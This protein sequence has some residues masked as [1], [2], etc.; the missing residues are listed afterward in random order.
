MLTRSH[1]DA[2]VKIRA[3]LTYE[4]NKLFIITCYGELFDFEF[5]FSR[6]LA[7]SFVFFGEIFKANYNEKF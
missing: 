1:L 3:T 5:K 7:R 2:M 4:Q 6:V